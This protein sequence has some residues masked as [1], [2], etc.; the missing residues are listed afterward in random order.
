MQG[1]NTRFS[2]GLAGRNSFIRFVTTWSIVAVSLA[3]CSTPAERITN[4]AADY[5]FTAQVIESR[6][7]RHQV[8]RNNPA[9]HTKGAVL[10]VYLEGDGTP[11]LNNEKVARDPTSR[12]SLMLGLMAV[13]TAPSL[14][15]GRPCYHGFSDS[16][17]CTPDLWT[18]ARYS[19]DV[20]VSMAQTLHTL[21][22]REETESLI[23]F[24]HSGG[25]VLAMLLA[26]RF[27]ETQAVVTIASNLDI[28]AWADMHR[29]TR[30]YRSLNPADRAALNP[31]IRQLHL[32]GGNDTNVTA[33]LVK[34]VESRQENSE[35]V[36]VPGFDHRC[37][38]QVIWPEVLAWTSGLENSAG[39]VKKG[40]GLN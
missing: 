35:L 40:V 18:D 3:A 13:D 15:L 31:R 9:D 22:D 24:G 8:Y 1:G 14:Y 4:E 38:W 19:E 28:D 39:I 33:Q 17:P 36:I 26:E 37:C 25:G 11:W 29:Y 32:V 2:N 20:I 23:F 21:V 5:G 27:D 12:K 10:H 30:L 16:P 7:F 34:G 6:K